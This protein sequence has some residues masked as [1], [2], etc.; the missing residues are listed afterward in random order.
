MFGGLGGL[1]PK[2]MQGM[3]KQ[4]G[5]AQQEIKSNKVIIEKEDG[6]NIVIDNPNVVKITMKGQNSYQISGDELE[7]SAEVSISKD[8]IKLVMEKTGKSEEKV[9]KV[10]ED[11]KD[12]AEA[13]V[14]LNK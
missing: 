4:L 12:I 9:K 14:K 3:M 13:I 1:N 10:L 7:E 8:D 6:N 2:K 5:I 11:T